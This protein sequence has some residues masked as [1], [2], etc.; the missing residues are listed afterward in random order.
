MNLNGLLATT[1]VGL[2]LAACGG[3]NAASTP[4][5]TGPASASALPGSPAPGQQAAEPAHI[6][7]SYSE[8]TPTNMALWGAKAAGIFEK[9]GLD[10]DLRLIE[11]NL[12]VG[13]L[14]GGETQVAVMGG[15]EALAA[16]VGGADLAVI[17]TISPVY[18]YKFEVRPEI[19]TKDDL[20]G[21]KV[22]VSKVGS[23]SDTATRAGLR[24]IGIDPDKDVSIIQVGSLTARVSALM[25]GAIQGGVASLPDTFQMEKEGLHPLFDLAALKLPAEQNCLIVRR[26]W[27]D[28]NRDTA[29]RVVGS[30]IQGMV[31]VRN[32]RAFGLQMLQE[33]LK[34]G[35]N[36]DQE[37]LEAT[38]EF[39]TKEAWAPLPYPEEVQFKDAVEQLASK[40]PAVKT[41]D[42]KSMLDASLVKS[43]ADRGLGK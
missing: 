8:L 13:A 37:A 15:T 34:K 7:L 33:N 27:L 31:K 6:V 12:G 21:K 41:F 2:L 11:S 18:P 23:S 10:V 1:L 38:Y 40:N 36:T 14:M 20:I 25:S 26:S 28:D 16:D 42:L 29:Q 32:D 30:L 24:K 3:G 19:K 17:A 35:R 9:N 4:P 22:G 39:Q 5:G 43:A